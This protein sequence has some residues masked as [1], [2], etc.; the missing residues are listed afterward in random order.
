MKPSQNWVSTSAPA[1]QVLALSL[2][3]VRDQTVQLVQSLS[4]ADA[5]AQSMPDASP[6]KWHL[7]HTTWFFETFVLVPH[8]ASYAVFDPAYKVLFNSYYN[9]VGEKH[10]RSQRGLITRPGLAQVLEYRRHVDAALARLFAQPHLPEGVVDLLTL[11]LNHE[12]QHQE[13][14]LTDLKHLLSQNPLNP[15]YSKPWP[16]TPVPLREPGWHTVQAGLYSV[17]FNQD[18][19][20]FDNEK[21]NHQVWLD[22]F[23]IAK[24]PVTNGDYIQFIE[25]GGYQRHELWLS[26]GWD[27]VAAQD[28]RAPH[29]WRLLDGQW[30]TFT[31]HG[32]VPVDP[33]TPV[34]HISF[35]EAEA[36]ARWA[37]ARLPTEEE[38]EVAAQFAAGSKGN[39]LEQG[40]FHPVP[41]AVS[42]SSAPLLQMFGDVWEWTRSDYKPYP[43]FAP[44]AGAVGEYN[45]KF[46]CN[47]YV[48]RGGSCVTPQNH[49][50]ASYRNFFPANARWQFSGLRLA[51]DVS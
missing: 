48:L 42:A 20:S 36:F 21:P 23:S 30:F 51:K 37:Q 41:C 39:H 40:M 28:W 43:R 2:Q 35:Y 19:F 24:Y 34:C 3:L 12:Q 47:Q 18:G 6:T 26:A 17:G 50:R 10:P 45:G 16:L 5:S 38:W 22:S 27:E 25:D 13:L 1:R 11:G 14:I 46:M 29:Y 44:A 9:G 32:L 7:A 15:V 8:L 31:L 4:E 33:N 49:I